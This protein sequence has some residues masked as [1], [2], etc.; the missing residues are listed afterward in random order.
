MR[1]FLTLLT[2]IFIAYPTSFGQGHR[3][4]QTANISLS[5]AQIDTASIAIIPFDATQYWIFEKSQPYSLTNIDIEAIELILRKWVNEYNPSQEQEFQSIHKN[6]PELNIDKANFIIDLQRYK[7]QYIAIINTKGEKEVWINC[8]CGE[9]DQNWKT[10]LI[11]IKDGGNCYFN[12]KV[13]LTT[14]K[15]YDLM[16]NGD[17]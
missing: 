3:E 1:E 16:V 2:F 13:N 8:F 17:S 11:V 15:Y 14:G 10:N 7:R 9:R 12:L 4:Y 5:K 6:H